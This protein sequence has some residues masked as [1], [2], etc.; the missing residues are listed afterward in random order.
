MNTI[1]RIKK[2]KKENEKDFYQTHPTMVK[3]LKDWLL[4]TGIYADSKFL[5]PCCGNGVIYKN[6]IDTFYNM[7]YFDKY[8]GHKRGNFQLHK[9]YYN[10]TVMNPP[11]S[12][13]RIYKFIDHA[14]KHS[15]VVICLLPLNVSNYNLFHENYQNTPEFVGKIVM[16]PKMFLGKTTEFK[17]GGTASYAWYIWD[18]KN[19]T[20]SS[21]E[22]YYNLR[23]YL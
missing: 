14:R 16:T 5:D 2:S 17:P 15:D 4:N 10:V 7:T 23:E 11:Y 3:V 21:K 18:H 8:M 6:L 20:N 1:R 22:W 13:K 12:D 19:Y 9:K